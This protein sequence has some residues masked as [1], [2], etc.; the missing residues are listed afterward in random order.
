MFFENGKQIAF[1]FFSYL[2]KDSALTHTFRAKG[3]KITIKLLQQ[4][5]QFFSL[6]HRTY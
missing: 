2:N 3:G 1:L 4:F 6:V 5:L